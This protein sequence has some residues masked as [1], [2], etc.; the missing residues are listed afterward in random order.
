[1]IERTS[2]A[3]TRPE[4]TRS[5]DAPA[6]VTLANASFAELFADLRA[7]DSTFGPQGIAQVVRD[8]LRHANRVELDDLAAGELASPG[9]SPVGSVAGRPSAAGPD[10]GRR[11]S[12][13]GTFAAPATVPKHA[14]TQSEAAHERAVLH[15]REDAQ[16]PSADQAGPLERAAVR[17]DP[18]PTAQNQHPNENVTAASSAALK[19]LGGEGVAR[20]NTPTGG[21]EAAIAGVGRATARTTDANFR[22]LMRRSQQPLFRV[23]KEQVP[24]QVSRSLA[25]IIARGGGRLTL[26]LSPR[27]L[28]DVRVDVHVRN[29][30]AAAIFRTENES[31]RDLLQHHLDALRSALEQRGIR[32]ERLEV[33]GPHSESDGS[34]HAEARFEGREPFDR[35]DQEG[36]A[37]HRRS[38][39]RPQRASAEADGTNQGELE[40][41]PGSESGPSVVVRRSAGGA[42]LRLDAIA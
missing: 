38:A 21:R 10:S 36:T 2:S 11:T 28:G 26:R 30:A 6:P 13:E 14:P 9:G 32:V 1:M 39:G 25:S 29:G 20:V 19:R 40:A 3:E 23:E 5:P 27:A 31:A 15:R 35:G 8:K 24:A 12:Q 16:Q 4:P 41:E 34:T 37:D 42:V 18:A 17:Q 7:H 33:V 22:S